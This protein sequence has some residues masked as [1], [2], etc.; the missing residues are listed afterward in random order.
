MDESSVITSDGGIAAVAGKAGLNVL[1]IAPGHILLDGFETGFIGGAA[2][3]LSPGLLAFTGRLDGHP[4]G[5]RIESFLRARRVEPLYLT[6]S[7]VFDV[8]S[9][10]LLTEQD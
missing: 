8:G 5:E 1:R 3:K 4:D 10:V 7:P 9:A 2:F 6:D